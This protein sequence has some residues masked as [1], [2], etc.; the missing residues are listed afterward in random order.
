MPE[1]IHLVCPACGGVNR[2]PQERLGQNPN[3]GRCKRPLFEG[4]ATPVD[5]A[6]FLRQ[7]QRSDEIIALLNQH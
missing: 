4:K 7:L 2:V 6:G 1:S 3:C 5:G